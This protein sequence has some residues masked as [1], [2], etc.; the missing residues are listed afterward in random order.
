MLPL[1]Y[2]FII[3]KFERDRFS[4]AAHAPNK[5]ISIK[6]KD[7]NNIYEREA[8]VRDLED[9]VPPIFRTLY[10]LMSQLE[11][12]EFQSSLEFKKKTVKV[13]DECYFKYLEVIK[14]SGQA[15]SAN[16]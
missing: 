6:N 3:Q 9:V 7:S 13:C 10:P 5:N 11:F 15:F 4:G 12:S 1:R 2:E 16:R 8:Y 14:D